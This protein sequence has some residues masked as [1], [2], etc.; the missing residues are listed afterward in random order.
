M[1]K[2][3]LLFVFVV[4]G[5]FTGIES[6][7]IPRDMGTLLVK[8]IQTKYWRQ[9]TTTIKVIFKFKVM[10][11]LFGYLTMTMMEIVIR[12]LLFA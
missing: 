4:G 6:G 7:F 2:L 8:I 11:K 9:H 1:K 12:D 3:I 5:Y 10:A